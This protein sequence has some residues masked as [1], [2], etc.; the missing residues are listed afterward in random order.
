ME[1]QIHA[2][3]IDELPS[4]RQL[5][6]AT[7]IAAGVAAVVLVTTIL[8]AEYGVD[9]TGIGRVLGLTPMGEMK[10][11]AAAAPEAEAAPAAEGAATDNGDILL[12]EEPASTAQAAGGSVGRVQLTLAPGQGE[13]VKAT[14]NAGDEFSYE[15]STGGP[16]I[17]F[18]LHGEPI[19]AQGDEFTSFEKGSSAGAKGKFR[20]PF[21]GTH[22]WYWLNNTDAPVTVTVSA[23]GAFQKFAKV[24]G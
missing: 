15:W 22:G 4:K 3:A 18:E 14:M 10:R 2:P 20:A 19:P 17:R 12:D 24:G 8:P 5:N 1:E 11:D 9:P 13:E 21:N 23:T 16:V 7:L 6:R